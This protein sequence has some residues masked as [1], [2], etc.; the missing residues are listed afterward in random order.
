MA[1]CLRR[2][3]RTR[4]GC[5]YAPRARELTRYEI[6]A[7]SIESTKADPPIQIGGYLRPVPSGVT[8]PSGSSRAG[9]YQCRIPLAT[10]SIR[11]T[12]FEGRC[13][14]V[15][16]VLGG[17]LVALGTFTRNFTCWP[18]CHRLRRANRG[19]G[20]HAPIRKRW[21]TIF[22]PKPLVFA[23]AWFQFFGCPATRF[24]AP[25]PVPSH[26]TSRPLPAD[27]CLAHSA[28]QPAAPG[29]HSPPPEDT[30]PPHPDLPASSRRVEVTHPR[31]QAVS[32]PELSDCL[33]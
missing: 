13:H 15:H 26:S 1:G 4:H 12:T 3:Q 32:A 8:D 22:G 23:W 33:H 9:V 16:V 20:E 30:G 14:V 24:A 7:R 6:G 19:Q 31:I 21:Q 2:S 27:P 17:A 11:G 18:P 29:A 25:S 10:A 28:S 5:P